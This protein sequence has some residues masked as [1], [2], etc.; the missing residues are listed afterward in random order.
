MNK[1]YDQNPQENVQVNNVR[2]STQNI[3]EVWP[4]KEWASETFT[5]KY[6]QM[7]L[8]S[9]AVPPGR[10]FIPYGDFQKELLVDIQNKIKTNFMQTPV[11][12]ITLT[13]AYLSI[14]NYSVN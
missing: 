8:K 2:N 7:Y 12:C 5:Y 4:H 3:L 10:W 6:E 11:N 1:R 9:K 13:T 14:T